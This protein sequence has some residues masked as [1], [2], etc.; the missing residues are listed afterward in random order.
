M[1]F[2][3]V[4]NGPVT[5][6]KKD[7]WLSRLLHQKSDRPTREK[8]AGHRHR[9]PLKGRRRHQVA[10]KPWWRLG[11]S[12][13]GSGSRPGWGTLSVGAVQPL[14]AEG[15]GSHAG[16]GVPDRKERRRVAVPG[17]KVGQLWH[18]RAEQVVFGRPG[19]AARAQALIN[20]LW[21]SLGRHDPC[22][23]RRRCR[24]RRKPR[25]GTVRLPS[26]H[27]RPPRVAPRRPTTPHRALRSGA[28]RACR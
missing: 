25:R 14:P 9:Q 18:G 11:D 2:S 10:A 20:D 19:V 1:G 15:L 22:R 5:D 13:A 17:R 12:E 23:C 24:G 26:P 28:P 7:P 21:R 16:L 8:R 3:R 4:P 27:P 6:P